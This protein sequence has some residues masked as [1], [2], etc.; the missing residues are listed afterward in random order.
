MS[1]LIK[2]LI[3]R[4]ISKDLEDPS[5]LAQLRF[6]VHDKTSQLAAGSCNRSRGEGRAV[7]SPADQR[8]DCWAAAAGTDGTVVR[9]RSEEGLSCWYLRQ[10]RCGGV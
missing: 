5:F 8:Q 10:S 7:Q 4:W 1:A 3:I 2:Y 6:L 9:E